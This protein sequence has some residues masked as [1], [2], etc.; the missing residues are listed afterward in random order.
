MH[1]Y[2]QGNGYGYGGW[3]YPPGTLPTYPYT[4][5]TYQIPNNGQIMDIQQFN[6]LMKVVENQTQT[7]MTH[8]LG[9]ALAFYDPVKGIR[10]MFMNEMNALHN[11]I[12]NELAMNRTNSVTEKR[13]LIPRARSLNDIGKAEATTIERI[14]A[15]AKSSAQA[16]STSQT[17]S[18]AQITM[19]SRVDSDGKNE[20]GIPSDFRKL[21]ITLEIM[22]SCTVLTFEL[23][24]ILD[25]LQVLPM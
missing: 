15:Q 1:Q 14:V 23:N 10:N 2:A 22:K 4:N 5:S 25:F 12:R 21:A 8:Q 11:T 13:N 9:T 19:V 16:S 20:M 18:S 6:Q 3:A 7:V 17:T 24:H